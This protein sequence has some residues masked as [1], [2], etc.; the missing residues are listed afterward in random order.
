MLNG[1]CAISRLGLL[2]TSDMHPLRPPPPP[3]P[4]PS[5]HTKE[6]MAAHHALFLSALKGHSDAISSV[7]WAHD[8]KA[9]VSACDD[10][11]LRVFDM[12]DVTSK[13]PKFRCGAVWLVAWSRLVGWL[14][15][16]VDQR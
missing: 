10:L 13:D 1:L 4:D 7:A 12:H 6:D 15:E 8:G 14:V 5:A 2:L 3:P 16:Y 9:L 11:T